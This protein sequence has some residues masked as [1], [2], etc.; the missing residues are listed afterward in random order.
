MFKENKVFVKKNL[1]KRINIEKG[2][3]QGF[4]DFLGIC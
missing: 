3:S 4:V 2:Y 1:D